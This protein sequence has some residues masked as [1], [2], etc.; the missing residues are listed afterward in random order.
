MNKPVI[1]FINPW[2][3]DF[4]AFDLYSKPL[5]LLYLSAFLRKQPIDTFF[6][7][8][9]DRY[10]P[11]MIKQF[12]NPKSK[13]FG[14]GPYFSQII[15]KPSF[16]NDIP[17][18]FK[19]YGMPENTVK[20]IFLRQK[21]PDMVFLTSLMTYWYPGVWKTA[22]LLREIFPETVIVLGGIYASLM[23]DH[24][25]KSGLFDYVITGPGE[26]KSLALLKQHFP[27]VPF[28]DIPLTGSTKIWPAFDYYHYLPYLVIL[29]STGCPFRCSFCASHLLNPRYQHR[30]YEEV[31]DEIVTQIAKF[32][33]KD[34]AFYDDA[35][36]VDKENHIKPLLR[37]LIKHNN[38]LRYHTPNGLHGKM[39]DKELAELMFKNN[40]QTIRISYE[41]FSDEKKND[42]SFKISN[43]EFIRSIEILNNAG[44]PRKNIEAYVIMGL[45]GQTVEEIVESML[46][47]HS[48][49]VQIRLASFSPIPGTEDFASAVNSNL[50]D[51][52]IDPLLCNKSIYPLHKKYFNYEIFS[53]LRQLN[54]VLNE[55]ALRG[56]N[57]VKD[58][59]LGNAFAHALNTV[60]S[61]IE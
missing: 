26:M 32:K 30:P 5:G 34:V 7:D 51:A 35:L 61:Y 36:L 19:M 50:I 27:N 18:H 38:R 47:V 28:K 58:K 1:W 6:L 31:Y 41:F 33:V 22:K 45:P 3:T 43:E 11:E 59:H 56:I 39:I 2:I 8:F 12:G 10:H 49:Q 16:L 29:T 54:Q 25:E 15:P 14:T 9:T 40:F 17:R 37:K 55:A 23:P 4:T 46:F 42:I 57:L 24:A 48:Q 13:K 60:N 21:K 44:F 20:D 53:G 52:N